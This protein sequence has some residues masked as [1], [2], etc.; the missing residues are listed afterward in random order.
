[1]SFSHTMRRYPI[2]AWRLPYT[3]FTVPGRVRRAAAETNRFWQRSIEG[4]ATMEREAVVDLMDATILR[5]R[6]AVTLQATL[7]LGSISPLYDALAGL[8]KK[9]GVGDTASLSGFGGAEIDVVSDLF[10]AAHGRFSIDEVVRRHG[11]HGPME[12]ELSSSVWREDPA[13]LHK[14]L[15]DYAARDESDDPRLHSERRRAAAKTVQKDVMAAL[16]IPARPLA[17]LL[18]RLAA[19]RIPMRGIPKRSF[20][21]LFDVL[22]VCARRLGALLAM[23]GK[24]Q[25][26]EDVFYLTVEELSGELPGNAQELIA[27]RRARRAVYLNTAVPAD[28]Q[29]APRPVKA[30]I[31]GARSESVVRGIGVSPGVVEGRARVLLQPDF[32]Q[33]QAGEILVTPTTD[34]SWSS[35]MF[36][37]I[38]LVVDI[39]GALSHAAIVAREL[40]IPCVVNTKHGSQML[41]TGDLVRID[42]S[43]GT[44]EILERGE[45][46]VA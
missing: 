11:F 9:S 27:L 29:G 17:W 39:G 14:L 25:A 32:A 10:R 26:P 5:F 33:V 30:Q 35:V 44:I 6:S 8:V 23:Q 40:G 4:V 36:I 37:S 34:P 42:G 12:G 3:F 22:R 21:Q 2:I 38:G 7:L 24:I 19:R 31:S 45:R 20:L 43:Q 1:M 46:L 13:P 16:P 15:R 41:R 18:L 28:W